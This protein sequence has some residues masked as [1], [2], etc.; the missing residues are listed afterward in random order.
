MLLWGNSKQHFY[1][2]QLLTFP[3]DFL[4]LNSHPSVRSVDYF[5]NFFAYEATRHWRT[6]L[7]V[8]EVMSSSSHSHGLFASQPHGLLSCPLNLESLLTRW[9]SVGPPSSLFNAQA[10]KMREYCLS[11]HEFWD[12]FA[13]IQ[14]HI[15]CWTNSVKQKSLFLPWFLLHFPAGQKIKECMHQIWKEFLI[16]VLSP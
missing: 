5:E 10:Y 6:A 4:I 11:C 2:I 1:L 7:P 15:F 16:Y 9:V 13:D 12:L 3:I 8:H 14:K